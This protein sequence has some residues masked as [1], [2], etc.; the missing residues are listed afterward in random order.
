MSCGV[1]HHLEEGGDDGYDGLVEQGRTT[2]TF[3]VGPHLSCWTGFTTYADRAA[4]A[5]ASTARIR[6]KIG[7]VPVS[8]PAV[9][10]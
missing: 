6:R 4:L 9:A 8:Q 5:P 1:S 10:A 7:W 3:N 2:L